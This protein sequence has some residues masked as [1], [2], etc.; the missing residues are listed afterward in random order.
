M[1]GNLFTNNDFST[2]IKTKSINGLKPYLETYTPD[3]TEGFYIRP[4]FVA[5]SVGDI[6]N[7]SNQKMMCDGLV[8]T[9]IFSKS[10]DVLGDI[11]TN[12]DVNCDNVNIATDGK[13]TIDTNCE[14]YR[15]VSACSSSDMRNTETNS[16]I[17]FIWG[18]PAVQ[19]NIVGAVNISTGWT[20]NTSTVDVMGN[21]F[22]DDVYVK[23]GGALRSN[24][25]APN[26]GALVTADT[27]SAV[28][29]SYLAT[30][31]IQSFD[32]TTV[33]FLNNIS[34]TTGTE[35][36]MGTTEISRYYD[37]INLSTIDVIFRTTNTAFRVADS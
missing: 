3:A 16:S 12:A 4:N 37:G 35:I 8:G 2:A 7:A 5:V 6:T 36:K 32:L 1:K 33:S 22:A 18:D 14:L 10:I 21:L 25:I 9:T 13:L 34:M 30:N 20:F 15:Y 31:T 27:N 24:N 26:G 28:Q 11:Y 29:N 19:S 17:R 23:T